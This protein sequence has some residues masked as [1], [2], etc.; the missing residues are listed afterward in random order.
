MLWLLVA[1]VTVVTPSSLAFSAAIDVDSIT[2][3]NA[4]TPTRSMAWGLFAPADLD[5]HL[6]EHAAGLRLRRSQR[7]FVDHGVVL[8]VYND[9]ELWRRGA[10]RAASRRKGHQTHK[11]ADAMDHNCTLT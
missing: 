8:N 7:P 10:D 4:G 3:L 9:V 2:T 1:N 5:A 6:R 11:Y